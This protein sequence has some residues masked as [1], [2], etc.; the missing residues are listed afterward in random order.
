MNRIKHFLPKSCLKFIYQSLI[1]SHLNYGILL[2]GFGNEKLKILQK[3]AIRILTKSHYLEHT[4]PLF[5]N[6]KILKVNDIFKVHCYKLF[7][8]F[9]NQRLPK[10]LM[11]LFNS[12]TILSINRLVNFNCPDSNG[13]K[14]IRYYLP[15]LINSSP[16]SIVQKVYTHSC[17]GFKLYLKNTI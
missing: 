1:H 17:K 2:W 5:R 4:D 3:K 6:E 15:Q 9:K 7:Y 13:K 14:R 16:I 10:K 11:T 12:Q 8:N